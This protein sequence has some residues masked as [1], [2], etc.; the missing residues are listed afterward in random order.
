MTQKRGREK[1]TLP[2]DARDRSPQGV[3]S[4]S[5]EGEG[6]GEEAKGK[7]AQ[8]PPPGGWRAGGLS[9]DPVYIAYTVNKRRGRQ[10]TTPTLR[11]EAP[12]V[13]LTDTGGQPS[14]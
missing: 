14:P 3:E 13:S 12:Q 6:S 9:P 4:E 5:E 11:L 2:R 7:D 8:G 1:R 10:K